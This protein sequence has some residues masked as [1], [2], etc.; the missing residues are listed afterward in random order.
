MA[1][2]DRIEDLP[3]WFKLDN[4]QGCESFGP[5]EW[6][7]QLLERSS[8][9]RACLELKNSESTAR[10]NYDW[11][12]DSIRAFRDSPLELPESLSDI[13]SRKPPV[14]PL[15]AYDLYMTA[16]EETFRQR[17][18]T[19]SGAPHPVDISVIFKKPHNAGIEVECLN[20]PHPLPAII[21][22]LGAND[23]TLKESFAIWLQEV[24]KTCP[25]IVT[26]RSK[27]AWDRW[28]RYGL[29]PYID[30]WIW[31]ME[32]DAHIPDRVMSAAVSR[33]DAGEANLRKTIAPLAE[34]LMCDLSALQA[35]AVVYSGQAPMG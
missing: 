31:S 21:V 32:T 3:K 24:R 34:D 12:E 5:T 11:Y 7:R 18:K 28:A 19:D 30:L 25:E 6:Y 22:D 17:G 35:L 2:I 14:R 4:Y 16:F 13:E 9:F 15:R 27:P 8:L 33:Y 20:S 23:S 29:L 10:S 26:K 1:K